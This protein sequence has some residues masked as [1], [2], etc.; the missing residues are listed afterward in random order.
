VREGFVD[1][2]RGFA[3]RSAIFVRRFGAAG[4]SDVNA[5]AD[6]AVPLKA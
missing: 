2:D 6:A 1:I 3:T 5:P 4:L